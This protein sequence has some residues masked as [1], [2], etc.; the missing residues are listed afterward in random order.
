M[1]D[2]L[3]MIV[4]F[5]VAGFVGGLMLF[6]TYQLGVWLLRRVQAWRFARRPWPVEKV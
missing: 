3:T 2:V 6:W 5:L 4:L 1:I